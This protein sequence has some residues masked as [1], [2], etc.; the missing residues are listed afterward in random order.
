M[1]PVCEVALLAHVVVEV[2]QLD[3]ELVVLF[4]KV[5]PSDVRHGDVFEHFHRAI[6]QFQRRWRH[7]GG[8]LDDILV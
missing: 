3:A 2:R 6:L 1:V 8:V 7:D 5:G 4:G